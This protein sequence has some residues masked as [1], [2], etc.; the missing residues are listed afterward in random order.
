MTTAYIIV[1]D[2]VKCFR[3]HTQIQRITTQTM[4]PY[5]VKYHLLLHLTATTTHKDWGERERGLLLIELIIHSRV[6]IFDFGWLWQQQSP[7]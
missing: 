6:E 2:D 3:F 4:G 7:A 5:I 1:D